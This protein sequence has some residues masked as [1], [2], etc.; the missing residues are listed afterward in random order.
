MA[1][2][3]VALTTLD[4]YCHPWKISNV[5]FLKIDTE[6]HDLFVLRGARALLDSG[7]VAFIEF[8][9]N[10]TWIASRTFLRDA[11]EF[12][13]SFGYKLGKIHR[14]FVEEFAN[15]DYR[16]EWFEQANYIAWISTVQ[17]SFPIVTTQNYLDHHKPQAWIRPKRH[18]CLHRNG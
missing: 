9:Y 1:M 2:E 4:E 7:S 17:P 5:L 8:E 13:K 12:M 16:L 10:S 15:W 14:T 11:F 18:Q 3:Q 6:G